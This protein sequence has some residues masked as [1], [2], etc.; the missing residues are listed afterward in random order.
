[1]ICM[2]KNEDTPE[3][4]GDRHISIGRL[5]LNLN[6]PRHEPVESEEKAIAALCD[7][8]LIAELA[9]DIVERGSLSPLEV[10]G[11]IPMEGHPGHF[12]SVEGNRRTCA[13]I[14][15]NDP[16]R[17]PEAIRPQLRALSSRA[18]LPKE[19]K[20]YVFA[21]E[22][23]AHQ[24]IQLRHLGSQGGAGTKGWDATQQNRA[25]GGSKKA[26]AHANTLAVNVLDRLV[27]RGAISPQQRKL[28]NLTTITRYVG[29]P[30]VRAI[31]GLGSNKDLLYTHD[32]DEVDSALLRLV[33]DSLTPRADGTYKVNSRTSSPDR[34]TY[35]HELKASGIAP[36]TLLD[37]PQ[38]APTATKLRTQPENS[39][40][41]PQK[42]SAVHPDARK[43][44]IPTDFRISYKD[45]ALSRLRREGLELELKDFTFSGNYLLRA[46]VEQVMTLY[47]KS[48]KKH[49]PGMTDAALTQ[50]CAE[51][52]KRS[53]VTGKAVTNLEKAAGAA[54]TG[55][56]LH[57]LGH[58]VHGGTI[59]TAI[60]LKKHFDT[61]RPSLEAMLEHLENGKP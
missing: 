61:W 34:L 30:G 11:V 16:S 25:A 59:P 29:T 58:A 31:L 50:A 10:L 15:A 44:L 12:V 24:W 18:S 3:Q 56:S 8:E 13:L 52:L 51:E 43:R 41:G 20:V 22:A 17:A 37:S 48:V 9:K 19:V 47:A 33:D 49:R 5:H 40:T 57:S 53:G 23:E 26:S 55:H 60:D 1:M 38:G 36:A 4:L 6:N 21:D 32:V 54:H 45:P 7:D 35:A 28:V 42:R 14:V 39:K 27:A 2:N 46:L